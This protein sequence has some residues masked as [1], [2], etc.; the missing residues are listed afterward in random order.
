MHL[1][2][3]HQRGKEQL[4]CHQL[5]SSSTPHCHSSPRHRSHGVLQGAIYGPVKLCTDSQIGQRI[6]LIKL[7]VSKKKAWICYVPGH[8]FSLQRLSSDLS[9]TQGSPPKNGPS[10]TLCLCWLPPPHV[11]LQL[12]QELQESHLPSTRGQQGTS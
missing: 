6:K 8:L 3:W 4:Q 1:Y 9:P 10:H 11:L 12:P 2:L 5:E 7:S